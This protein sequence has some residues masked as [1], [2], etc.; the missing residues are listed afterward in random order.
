MAP[1]TALAAT[2]HSNHRS[3]RRDRTAQLF[4]P[5]P[6][7]A[8]APCILAIGP[9]DHLAAH[10][11]RPFLRAALPACHS[12]SRPLTSQPAA[13]APTRP[14]TH[15]TP[16]HHSLAVSRARPADAVSPGAL[17]FVVARDTPT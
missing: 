13:H 3:D 8:R 9:A 12:C 5:A 10:R 11:R 4:L 15:L 1:G 16:A 2:S 7:R 14:P 6:A 17:S